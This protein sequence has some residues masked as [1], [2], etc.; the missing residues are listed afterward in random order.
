MLLSWRATCFGDQICRL[1]LK[2]TEL[3]MLLI[4]PKF[5]LPLDRADYEK[6]T[7][8]EDDRNGE[9]YRQAYEKYHVGAEGP[10]ELLLWPNAPGNGIDGEGWGESNRA[11]RSRIEIKLRIKASFASSTE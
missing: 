8:D 3:T 5:V 9:Y 1:D 11:A 4:L 7:V 2:R 10:H 6:V